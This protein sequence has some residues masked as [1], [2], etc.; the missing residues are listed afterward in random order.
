MSLAIYMI[1]FMT[2]YTRM[3][4]LA[5]LVAYAIFRHVEFRDSQFFEII[6]GCFDAEGGVVHGLYQR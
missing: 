6:E 4:Q 5:D 2:H 3:I 1:L